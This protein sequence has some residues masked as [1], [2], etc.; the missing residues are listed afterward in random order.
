MPFQDF[1]CHVN[2]DPDPHPECYLETYICS[3]SCSSLHRHT[4]IFL[5]HKI[6]DNQNSS[7][8]VMYVSMSC[9]HT[10]FSLK[11]LECNTIPAWEQPKDISHCCHC[12]ALHTNITPFWILAGP[13]LAIFPTY[14]IKCSSFLSREE[15][16]TAKI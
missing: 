4:W 10:I 8:K 14:Q 1:F 15:P 11:I 9:L 3:K 2:R 6:I 7:F 13:A 5:A 12:L 16:T